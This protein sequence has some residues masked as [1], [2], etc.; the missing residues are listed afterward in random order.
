MRDR[1]AYALV[2]FALFYFSSHAIAAAIR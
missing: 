2:A 1:L